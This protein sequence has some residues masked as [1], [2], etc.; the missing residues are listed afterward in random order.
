MTN[1]RGMCR[2]RTLS[3]ICSRTRRWFP[4]VVGK[5]YIRD[6]TPPNTV[7][8]HTHGTVFTNTPTH[9]HSSPAA[10]NIDHMYTLYLKGAAGK[11]LEF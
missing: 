7:E 9:T 6:M 10:L 11:M 1:C 4:S 3:A 5:R 8:T 2:E